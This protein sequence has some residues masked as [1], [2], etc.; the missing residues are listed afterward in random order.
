MPA[1]D[2]PLHPR[3]CWGADTDRT[4]PDPLAVLKEPTSK[5]RE[6]KG[7]RGRTGKVREGERRWREGFGPPKNFGVVPLCHYYY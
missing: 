1:G 2:A 3:P 6:R 4:L 7:E 5:R